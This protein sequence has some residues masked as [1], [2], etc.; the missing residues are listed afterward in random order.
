ME[1]Q[2]ATVSRI[3]GGRFAGF[4]TSCSIL[5]PPFSDWSYACFGTEHRQH[6]ERICSLRTDWASGH[7]THY[8]LLS[9]VTNGE[10][11][12]VA[13]CSYGYAETTELC[14]HSDD[15]PEIKAIAHWNTNPKPENSYPVSRVGALWKYD[16]DF[17]LYDDDTQPWMHDCLFAVSYPPREVSRSDPAPAK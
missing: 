17:D 8:R 4:D 5:S 12:A 13:S 16:P 6:R 3:S 15:D 11:K 1:K 7:S 10:P 9:V 14:P 2:Q